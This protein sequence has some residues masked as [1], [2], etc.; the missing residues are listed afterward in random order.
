MAQSTTPYNADVQTAASD[1]IEWAH[2]IFSG[3]QTGDTALVNTWRRAAEH[4]RAGVGRPRKDSKVPTLAQLGL[5][6]WE[7]RR[8]LALAAAN[9]TEEQMDALAA[10]KPGRSLTAL[11]E[12]NSR[13]ARRRNPLFRAWRVA[14]S[15]ERQEFIDALRRLAFF[16]ERQDAVNEIV[17]DDE[18]PARAR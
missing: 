11:L 14:L 7:A 18:D 9:L 2:S 5:T 6:K 16:A 12:H 4:G 1:E 17:T 8:A 10:R 15:A 3:Q 13:R